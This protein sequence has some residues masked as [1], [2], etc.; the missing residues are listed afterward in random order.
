MTATATTTTDALVAR[1]VALRAAARH[2]L[3]AESL[4]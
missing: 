2:H 4:R 3:L 1:L